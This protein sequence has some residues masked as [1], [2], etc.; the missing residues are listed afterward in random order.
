MCS[1]E[2]LYKGMG[3]KI[4]GDIENEEHGFRKNTDA[5]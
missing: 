3:R 2:T 5:T 1:S 4:R